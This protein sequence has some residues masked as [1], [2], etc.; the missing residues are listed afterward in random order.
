MT[1]SPK[2]TPNKALR[3]M[4]S[5]LVLRSMV[6]TPA[7]THRWQ[8]LTPRL[9]PSYHLLLPSSRAL[10]ACTSRQ[11]GLWTLTVS[12]AL[13]LWTLSLSTLLAVHIAPSWHPLILKTSPNCASST[14]LEPAPPTVSAPSRPSSTAPALSI[15]H[16]PHRAAGVVL[17]VWVE[18][19]ESIDLAH[20]HP[21][22]E[23]KLSTAVVILQSTPICIILP[24]PS[25]CR[26]TTRAPAWKKTSGVPRSSRYPPCHLWVLGLC[27]PNTETLSRLQLLS[28][29]SPQPRTLPGILEQT[30]VVREKW[31]WEEEMEGE[32]SHRC[33]LVAAQHT[34]RLDVAKAPGYG[35]NPRGRSPQGLRH[36]GTTGIPRPP[37]RVTVFLH[38][39]NSSSAAAVRWSSRRASPRQGPGKNWGKSGSSQASPEAWRSLKCP[40]R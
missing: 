2:T 8:I 34:W 13:S 16:S 12:N 17:G 35:T 6:T 10:T 21:E 32:R 30:K 22:P 37:A 38:Q 11:R 33:G 7:V 36:R 23:E 14:A 29:Q 24:N 9:N 28:L 4:G 19:K 18:V 31:S 25:A 15:H 3:L 20:P 1:R 5:L 40:D 27:G 39:K 26:W